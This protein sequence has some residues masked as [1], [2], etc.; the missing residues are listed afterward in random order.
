MRLQSLSAMNR[1]TCCPPGS[2]KS[3]NGQPHLVVASM[4]RSGTHL[5]INLLLNNFPAFKS[6]P[7]YLNLDMF[8]HQGGQLKDLDQS[9]GFVVKTHFPQS[10]ECRGHE[11]GLKEFLGRNKILLVSRDAHEVKHSLGKFGEWG[12]AEVAH[13][14]QI[15]QDFSH[16]WDHEHHGEVMRVKYADLIDDTKLPALLE[17]LEEFTGLP[18]S[19]KM[20]GV[21]A[22]KKRLTILFWKAATRLLG[23]LSP[24]INTGIKL[25]K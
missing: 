20:M 7:L 22:K 13:F 1:R 24:R 23:H 15:R 16:Y 11:D 21:V 12:A 3:P 8:V 17:A 18:R 5:M 4:M 14:A 9:G 10:I 2:L 6:S 25:G 19:S